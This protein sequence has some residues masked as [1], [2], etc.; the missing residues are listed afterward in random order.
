[1]IADAGTKGLSD[2]DYLLS[3][4]IYSLT[5]EKVEE[6]LKQLAAKRQEID[7]LLVLT[8]V[9]L[10]QRDLDAFEAVWKEQLQSRDVKTEADG[11]KK[12]K[13]RKLHKRRQGQRKSL[14]KVLQRKF[15]SCPRSLKHW[16]NHKNH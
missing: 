10:W 9:D 8:P 4:P 3:M 6:L 14:K 5:A 15:K 1:M 7:Q 2:F 11:G 13:G 16:K 12:L